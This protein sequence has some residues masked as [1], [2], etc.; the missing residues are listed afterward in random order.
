MLLVAVRLLCKLLVKFGP[1]KQANQS[2]IVLAGQELS[3]LKA[4]GQIGYSRQVATPHGVDAC[5]QWNQ[6]ISVGKK[7]SNVAPS[8]HKCVD[9][10]PRLLFSRSC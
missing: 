4:L 5:M 8:T 9:V 10:R 3:L 7:A 2:G 1:G 6:N